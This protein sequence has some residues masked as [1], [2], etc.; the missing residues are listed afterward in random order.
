ML[1]SSLVQTHDNQKNMKNSLVLLFLSLALL[2]CENDFSV[3]GTIS[4]DAVN[5]EYMYIRMAENGSVVTIDSCRVQ[6]STFEMRGTADSAFVASLYIGDIPI[7]PFV[8][9]KGNI[10]FDITDNG[11]ELGGTPLNDEL[12]LFMREQLRFEQLMHE[13]KRVETSL[14]LNGRS[15]EAAA[16]Y[17]SDSIEAVGAS[18][19]QLVDDYVRRNINN[20]LGP[21]IFALRYSG[22]PAPILNSE[23]ESLYNDA[24]LSFRND[25]FVKHFYDVARENANRLERQRLLEK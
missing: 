7:L 24:P 25:A 3:R 6:H 13:L 16:D 14:V 10:V 18:V 21:C 22:V 5:G 9:E 1:L 17:V 11:I 2:S 8:A 20:V 4:S 12:N 19:E 15:T 23:L